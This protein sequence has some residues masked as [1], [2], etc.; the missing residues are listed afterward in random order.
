MADI[1]SS[2][3]LYVEYGGLQSGCHK[4]DSNGVQLELHS[5]QWYHVSEHLGE[6]TASLFIDGTIVNSNEGTVAE[7]QVHAE[8]PLRVGQYDEATFPLHGNIS[9]LVFVHTVMSQRL[10]G[11]RRLWAML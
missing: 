4:L 8:G 11:Q 10:P 5:I 7:Q 3:V 2:H 9:H 6:G 1:G